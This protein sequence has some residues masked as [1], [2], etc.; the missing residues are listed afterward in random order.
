[1]SKQQ[2]RA[3]YQYSSSSSRIQH[4]VDMQQH[5]NAIPRH[6]PPLISM[7]NDEE[8]VHYNHH[9]GESRYD[10]NNINNMHKQQQQQIFYQSKTAQPYCVTKRVIKYGEI[11]IPKGTLGVVI[12]SSTKV[13]C[14]CITFTKPYNNKEI[15]GLT[16]KDVS[17]S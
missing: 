5:S 14:K 16:S 13:G 2:P 15:F 1:M 12:D 6:P 17:F 4:T 10:D 7:N 8:N 11:T 3:R 9:H